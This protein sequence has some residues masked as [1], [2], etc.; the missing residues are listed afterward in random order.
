MFCSCGW[1]EKRVRRLNRRIFLR[2]IF[3]CHGRHDWKDAEDVTTGPV[4]APDE[5]FVVIAR[6]RQCN[7]C[8]TVQD[9]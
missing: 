4:D 2:S 9:I 6:I 8:W 3:L 7:R 5:E 1:K